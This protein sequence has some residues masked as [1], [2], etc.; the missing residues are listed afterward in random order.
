MDFARGKRNCVPCRMIFKNGRLI[1]PNGVRDGLDLLVENGMIT[2]IQA[3][4]HAMGEKIVD[5]DGNYLAPGFIDL[6]VHGAMG[7][8]TMQASA[9]A[10]RTI[11]DYHASGGTT[12]MLLTTATSPIRAIVKVVNEVRDAKS[13][14]KQIAGVHVE[15]PFISKA[16]RGAQRANLIRHPTRK[17]YGPLLEYDDIIK[18]MTL[19]PEL[20]GAVTLID[21]LREHNISVSGGH[22]DA[23][24]DDAR[25]AFEHGMQSVTHTFNC[26]SSARRRGTDRV[27]GLLEF[28]MSEPEIICEL[29]ADGHHVSPTLMKMLYRAKGV[30]GICLVTDATAGAGL[31]DGSK[32][33][34]Y[35]TKCIVE[36]GV[37]LLAD[38]S[39]LA[40]S[41]ARMIDLVRTMVTKVGVPLHEAIA[42]AT[43]M[44]AFVI[45]LTSK[46]QFKIGGD[47]DLVI[48]SPE[49][50]V[51]RTFVAGEEVFQR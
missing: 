19:A 45:G 20:P 13:S 26:M 14:I 27:A 18:R 31:P 49:L 29:I 30:R 5:L 40:G 35:G 51:L 32:F 9:K 3:Q 7:R 37:C 16:K 24:E 50:E 15:G 48:I 42:M 4:A 46:G 25:S 33:S 22:S 1:F 41:A 39:A 2:A 10:F 47:A 44:P 28:A 34:L 11:C 36:D 23:W 43:D 8:D 38:R 6:H 21:E 17:M 12:S